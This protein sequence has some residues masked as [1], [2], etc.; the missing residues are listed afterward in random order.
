MLFPMKVT[1]NIFVCMLLVLS[2]AYGQGQMQQYTYYRV[3]KDVSEQWSSIVLP[4]DIFSKVAP[5]FSDIRI[6]GITPGGDTIESPY[7]L[8]VMKEKLSDKVVPLRVLNVT[9]NEKG[10]YF[11]FEV[12]SDEPVNQIKTGFKQQNF[13][14]RVALEGSQDQ[15]EWFTLID[16]YRILSIKN[17]WADFRFTTLTFPDAK[18]RYY[19][20]FVDATT[21]PDLTVAE[22][23]KHEIT[24]GLWNDYAI[25]KWEMKTDRQ[26]KQ[27]EIDMELSLPVPV[28]HIKIKVS[29]TFDY[30]RPVTIQYL[31]DSIKTES[32]W[33]Y[34]YRT[35]ASGVLNS[36]DT[37]GFKFNTVVAGKLKIII[38]NNDNHPLHISALHVKG[39]VHRMIVRFAQDATY[40]LV[41]G[42]KNAPA[43]NY[44]LNYFADKI[45]DSPN[46]LYLGDEQSR[47][48]DRGIEK[49]PLFTDKKWLWAVIII[50]VLL[51][52][53]FSIKMIR[54]G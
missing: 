40:Y 51:L 21:R 33:N 9:G 34:R 49:A 35:L 18:Y 20:L 12:L 44:D 53:W 23:G 30:Y 16:R 38:S 48:K 14:W 5:D 52:G 47:E 25:K 1:R 45:P 32:G 31:A 26:S 6:F 24:G 54:N 37:S 43:P 50:A 17:E 13:D 3:L 42:N 2:F 15:R 27:S 19:R 22:T 11:T 28:D 41:Y 36:L 46:Q 8:Q 39:Y 29:D 4:D 7:L 10:F